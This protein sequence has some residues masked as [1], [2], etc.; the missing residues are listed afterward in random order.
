MKCDAICYDYV[1]QNGGPWTTVYNNVRALVM[2]SWHTT[3][4][5]IGEKRFIC[6][7]TVKLN[8][9]SETFAHMLTMDCH[10]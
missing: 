7:T 10:W 3:S 6:G 2:F 1:H 8:V 4:V 9:Q 5:F